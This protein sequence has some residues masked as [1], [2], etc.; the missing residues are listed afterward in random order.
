MPIIHQIVVQLQRHQNLVKG[1]L[2]VGN[3]TEKLKI[4]GK[5]VR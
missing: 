3:S 1:E 5:F 2:S 4:D